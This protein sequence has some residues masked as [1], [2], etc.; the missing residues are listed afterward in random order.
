MNLSSLIHNY[1]LSTISTLHI[2]DWQQRSLVSDL[3]AVK[4][5]KFIQIVAAGNCFD[6]GV[7]QRAVLCLKA[8]SHAWKSIEHWQLLKSFA[9]VLQVRDHLCSMPT[10][11]DG[12]YC[13]CTPHSLYSHFCT[14]PG[15][16][17]KETTNTA[18]LRE[19]V[20]PV[21]SSLGQSSSQNKCKYILENGGTCLKN[22]RVGEKS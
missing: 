2:W 10:D 17:W 13:L 15:R 16:L 14:Y 4:V 22:V 19:T 20:E 3:G 11:K 8:G 1:S 5:R 18:V 7:L 21:L 9:C 12:A 6:P